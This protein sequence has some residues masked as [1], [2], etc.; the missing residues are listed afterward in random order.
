MRAGHGMRWGGLAGIGAVLFAIAGHI[1]LGAMPGVADPTG[2]I[3]AYL[4][5]HRDQIIAGAMLYAVAIL[6]L[7]WFGAALSTA[8]RRADT[9]RDAPAV[10]FAGFV[11]VC[12]ARFIAMAMFAGMT[13]ALTADPALLLFAAAPYTA[14]TI[15]GTV[16]DLAAALTLAA[17]ASAITRTRVL[18]RWTAWFAAVVAVVRLLAACTVGITGGVLLPGGRLVTYLP[19]VLTGLWLLVTGGLLLRAHLPAVAIRAGHAVRPGR[20]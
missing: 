8:F 6:L 13:Y 7:L 11:I 16:T 19:G 17:T 1:V 14:M 5:R 3:A 9:A 2:V 18:P 4:A 10:V 20:A 12:A 15:A